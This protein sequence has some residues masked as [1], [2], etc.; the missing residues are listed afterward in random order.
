MELSAVADEVD[1]DAYALEAATREEGSALMSAEAAVFGEGS[2]LCEH[3]WGDLADAICARLHLFV[4]RKNGI[5]VL[6]LDKRYS[7]AAEPEPSMFLKEKKSEHDIPVEPRDTSALL[8]SKTGVGAM[9]EQEVT[10]E[11]TE[12]EEQ[13]ESKAEAEAVEVNIQE[14][15]D[16]TGVD[17]VV[18]KAQAQAQAQEQWER[19]LDEET[20][21][22]YWFNAVTGESR[23]E[24]EGAQNEGED[25][26]V[27][28]YA[29]D[30]DEREAL[31]DDGAI[32][33]IDLAPIRK[34][35]EFVNQ[36]L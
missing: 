34:E 5:M 12:E 16:A 36:F 26:A 4:S 24:D 28:G 30:G 31:R 10:E 3:R 20:G 33:S 9:E 15:E 7:F 22:Y 2:V 14:V 27:G 25:A 35:Q 19:F 6:S 32:P 29:E 11:V 8:S 21:N 18:G 17:A 13:K 23:W 1:A